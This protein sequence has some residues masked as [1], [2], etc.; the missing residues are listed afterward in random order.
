[1]TWGL[2]SMRWL[3][4]SRSTFL[5]IWGRDAAV[6][7]GR[8]GAA[9]SKAPRFPLPPAGLSAPNA[10]HATPLPH[11]TLQGTLGTPQPLTREPRSMN[12]TATSS[13]VARSRMSLATPKF[14]LPMSR[15]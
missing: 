15:I 12:L 6:V 9:P 4:I 2:F 8:I 11:T 10:K 14:P 7:R 13:L 5:S 3:R 1:M